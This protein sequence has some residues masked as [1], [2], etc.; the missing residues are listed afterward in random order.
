MSQQ[1]ELLKKSAVSAIAETLRQTVEQQTQEQIDA[2][3]DEVT[4]ALA[5]GGWV[6]VDGSFETGGVITAR[7]QFLLLT[8]A[9]GLQPA[10][11]WAWGGVIPAGGYVVP[12][13][14]SP[15][16]SGGIAPNAWVYHGDTT[17][18]GRH[19]SDPAAH[20]ELSAFI[21]TE[22]N[23]AEIAADA[24]QLAANVYPTTAAGL[25]S[26]TDGQYFSVVSGSTN[27]YLS[28]YL[29]N[30]GTAVLQK[31]YPSAAALAAIQAEVAS[32]EAD[33]E[34]TKF[35]QTAIKK[36]TA[37]LFSGQLFSGAQWFNGTTTVGATISS[38]GWKIPAGS[39]GNQTYNRYRFAFTA[40][41]VAALAGRTCRFL[42][43]FDTSVNFFS[44]FTGAFA[45]AVDI[46][47]TAGTLANLRF[48]ALNSTKAI[49][50]F[51]YT[52]SGN[53]TELSSYIQIVNTAALTADATLYATGLFYAAM[54]ARG[55]AEAAAEI[56]AIK[57]LTA[58]SA[59][60]NLVAIDERLLISPAGQA[61]NGAV[62]SVSA[63]SITV[64]AG[65]S[66]MNSYITYSLPLDRNVLRSG[67]TVTLELVLTT[68]DN[69]LTELNGARIVNIN[70]RVDGVN[71]TNQ[72]V[73]G[74]M[75][76][77]QTA[78]NELTITGDY[79]LRGGLRETAGIF[80]QMTQSA[81]SASGRSFAYKKA[82]Y[83]LKS[84]TS[85][86]S[87]VIRRLSD[88]V[89]SSG[90]LKDV[91]TPEGQVFAGATVRDTGYG[92]TV[93]VGQTGANSYRRFAIDVSAIKK[94]VGSIVRV[95]ML[96]STS[97][98]VEAETPLIGNLSAFYSNT[99]PIYNAAKSSSRT[100]LS[101]KLWLC[102]FTYTIV[103][104]ETRLAPY[105]QIGVG[106]V[107]RTSEGFITYEDLRFVF[108]NAGYSAGVPGTRGYSPAE[109]V[110]K[111]RES[112]IQQSLNEALNEALNE[113]SPE[114]VY[115]QTVTVKSDGTGDF[116]TLA[117]AI[118][119][120]G[121]GESAYRR[122]L[123]KVFEGVY[124]DT[125]VAIPNFADVIGIGI[126]EN[127]WFKGEL[128]DNV[129]PSTI[130]TVQTLWMNGTTKLKNVKVTAR[131]MRYPIH[132]DSGASSNRALQEIEDCYIE[133]L[134]NQ[135]AK[136]YQSANG[137]DPNSVWGS[138][139]AWGCG[140][141]SGQ[142]IFS[143][144]TKWVSRTSPFYF[145]T[146][147]DF[148]EPCYVE[149]DG[150][151]SI[152]TTDTGSALFVQPLGSG[153]PDRFVI[154]NG[155]EI[156]GPLTVSPS[157]WLSTDIYNQRGD[158]N[159]EV[160]I[161]VSSSS[162]IAWR[163]TNGC[164]VLELRSVDSSTSAV[165]V[166]G[167]GADA[168]FGK[169]PKYIAGGVGYPSR[170]YSKHAITGSV[171]GVS[172]GERLGDCSSV[173]KT[174]NIVFDGS[175][176]KT[177]TLNQDYSA[178]SNA[179]VIASLNTALADGTRAFYV[180]NPYNNTPHI[181]QAEYER[182]VL[183]TGASAI[184]KGMA[185]AFDGSQ[186]KGRIATDSD[187][188]GLFAGVAL[189]NIVTGQRGRIL[190]PGAHIHQLQLD[191]SVAPS[192][193]YGDTFGVSGTTGKF[194]EGAAVPLIRCIELRNGSG[195]FE[196]L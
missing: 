68:S 26:T 105:F 187:A 31:T 37:R 125:N 166:S 159:S 163:S 92:I 22:A 130:Q 120:N 147:K 70:N 186:F 150:G 54:D 121:G 142:K 134:G 47:G 176:N 144:R 32:L 53:E 66:G 185:V 93:P 112:V 138:E 181:F 155:C 180:S 137:G 30:S 157:P 73:G 168:L 108:D 25:A 34:Y 5:S 188:A 63:M 101:P 149:L 13:G 11:S 56:G 82:S 88:A 15:E 45:R 113:L 49:F 94:F 61:F 172:L 91:V 24:A 154:K 75:K 140:T 145:H 171:V 182:T 14:S 57:T 162:P 62:Y 139:H 16:T 74:T 123:Y 4:S 167:T 126:C 51:D 85:N 131:N 77:V 190:K 106:A 65:S 117:A 18:V 152:C 153:Q 81:V 10:G 27:E 196:V 102:E 129:T 69:L 87:A 193:T 33:N 119:A 141:H 72:A 40:A 192:L 164:N 60:N 58:A 178:M 9:V 110:L 41:E 124:N 107:A 20:P 44:A 64:P 179:T 133:H 165:A 194:V 19:N 76:I 39:T 86:D 114:V 50:T 99:G 183:N 146:N 23:R 158:Q 55:A 84:E 52:F 59:E 12:P 127:I 175:V 189:E 79:V 2:L 122:V 83:R 71:S 36:E 95:Q 7:N 48:V 35:F 103:G 90:D 29:N 143:R 128:P 21:T 169:Q 116:T 89:F 100:K 160:E 191:F 96:V 109:Q 1:F 28:L 151:A 156:H 148:A 115:T 97:A 42:I 17:L 98:N 104:T 161:Y 174:L 118:A 67:Q 184:L 6:P 136:D 80:F 78:T 43:T 46:I 111:F 3:S 135:G 170:V 132:S 173:N 177:I 195:I 8:T 38:G